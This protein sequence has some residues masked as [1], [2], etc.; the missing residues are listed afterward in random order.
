MSW[1]ENSPG[2]ETTP[3]LATSWA[4]EGW[5]ARWRT[6]PRRKPRRASWE[7]KSYR[8]LKMRHL[9]SAF[10]ILHGWQNQRHKAFNLTWHLYVNKLCGQVKTSNLNF[11]TFFVS[12]PD[13]KM[14]SRQWKNTLDI[15]K[16][17]HTA[18]PQVAYTSVQIFRGETKIESRW[19]GLGGGGGRQVDRL[20][21][22]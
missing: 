7:L 14:F 3:L 18:S 2:R 19:V 12:Q 16:I 13:I 1:K 10:C 6:S 22:G 21:W 15:L 20:G 4:W 9:H 8:S 17:V 5:Q 11:H